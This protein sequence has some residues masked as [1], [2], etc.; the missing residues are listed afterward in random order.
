MNET[1]QLLEQ[2]AAHARNSLKGQ[3]KPLPAPLPPAGLRRIEGILG[4]DLPPLL[5]GLYTRIADGGF[6]PEGGLLTLGQAA[7][8]YAAMRTSAWRWPEG[9]LPI[10]DF[11]CG[12]YACVDCRSE[13][14]QVLL[15]EPNPG[16]PDLA[17]Y[18]DTPGLADWLRGWIDGTAWYCEDSA[19]GEEFD[20]ELRLWSEFRSRV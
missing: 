14:A 2:V 5:A 15:F 6:G 17:W 16:D 11:G 4:F 7:D 10:A 9:V 20:L 3:R 19:A 12:L 18:V 13:T 1:E 8:A